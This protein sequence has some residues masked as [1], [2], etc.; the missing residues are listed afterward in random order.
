V[1]Q[2]GW[3]FAFP[4]GGQ[5]YARQGYVDHKTILRIL[6]QAVEERFGANP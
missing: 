3:A 6:A 1:D 4:A 5:P 2:Y